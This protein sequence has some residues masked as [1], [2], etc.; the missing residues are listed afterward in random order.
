[1][2]HT[3]SLYAIAA[4]FIGAGLGHVVRPQF[5]V[6]IMPPY[7]PAPQLLVYLSGAAEIAGGIGLLLP[8][9]RVYAGWGLIGLLVAFLAVHVYMSRHP[10]AFPD[11]PAWALHVRLG[12]QFALIAWVYWAAC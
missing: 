2:L 4:M 1:M 11:V 6:R 9:W 3:L 7:L 12:L 5:F 10:E 8:A